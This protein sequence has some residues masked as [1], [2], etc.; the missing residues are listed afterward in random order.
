M[1]VV[2][3]ISDCRTERAKLHGKLVKAG[4]EVLAEGPEGLAR[5]IAAEVPMWR[6]VVAQ[7]GI[8]LK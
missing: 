7:T 1:T 2:Q 5:R 6:E 8:K 3:R 4:F